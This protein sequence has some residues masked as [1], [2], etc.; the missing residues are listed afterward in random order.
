MMR[1]Y[2][3]Q[4]VTPTHCTVGRNKAS[5]ITNLIFI[6][7]LLILEKVDDAINALEIIEADST[8]YDVVVAAKNLVKDANN[9]KQVGNYDVATNLMTSC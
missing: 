5:I 9:S 2:P 3:R 4:L 8:S 6:E 1:R 7:L